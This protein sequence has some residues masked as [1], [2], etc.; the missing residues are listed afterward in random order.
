MLPFFLFNFK[1]LRCCLVCKWNKKLKVF[2]IYN[3]TSNTIQ[4]ERHS[5]PK[6]RDYR[7]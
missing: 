3:Q 6:V 1:I 7:R 5:N 2:F 4:D